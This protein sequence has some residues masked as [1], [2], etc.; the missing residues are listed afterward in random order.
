MACRRVPSILHVWG[1]LE[2]PL[3]SAV[4]AGATSLIPLCGLGAPLYFAV[5]AW[6][7]LFNLLIGAF[8]IYPAFV[9]PLVESSVEVRP[10]HVDLCS[11]LVHFNHSHLP[12]LFV[13]LRLKDLLGPVTRVKKKK[14]S[15]Q[16]LA[17][18]GNQHSREPHW[19]RGGLVFKAH[20]LCASL[21]SRLESNKEEEP[22]IPFARALPT[23]T[24]VESG[25]SQSKSGTSVNLSNSGLSGSCS[26]LRCPIQYGFSRFAKDRNHPTGKPHQHPPD[27]S[28]GFKNN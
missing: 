21:N 16:R 18:R 2:I 3:L 7:H 26:H 9:D 22:H 5:W 10:V 28:V 24:N 11:V 1:F 17:G 8:E 6:G 14:T 12:T 20:R 27:H 25:T 4:W 19:F 23:E 13:S 15:R